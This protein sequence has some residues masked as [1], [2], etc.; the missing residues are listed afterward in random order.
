MIA[1][2]GATGQLGT[3]FIRRLPGARRLVRPDFDLGGLTPELVDAAFDGVDIVIN[4]AAYTAVDRAESEEE[5]ATTVNG[6]AV[7]LMAERAGRRGIRFVTYSTDYVF[8][9]TGRSPWVESS[10]TDPINAYGRSKLAGE[11]AVEAANPDALVIRTSWVISPTHPNFVAMMLRLTADDRTLTVVDDQH[12]CPTVTTDLAQGTLEA[13]EAGMTGLLHICNAGPT[14]WFELARTS[15]ELAGRDP[16]LIE[17]CTT[18]DYPTPARRPA[19]SVLASERG[20][21]TLPHWRDSLPA[22]VAGLL[23]RPETR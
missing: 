23:A 12:G 3:A 5:L 11:L 17:P 13:L 2:V 16:R 6:T 8:P 21:P 18:A 4:C 1:V 7:G 10:P 20:A 19:Y 15:V 22:V 9:G 14:T